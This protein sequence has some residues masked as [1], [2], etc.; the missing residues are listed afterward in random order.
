MT[1]V[2]ILKPQLST[3]HTTAKNLLQALV[4]ELTAT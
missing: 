2:H 1:L 4:G 3:S